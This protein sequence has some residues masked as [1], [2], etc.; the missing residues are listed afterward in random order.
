MICLRRWRVNHTGRH[1]GRV[2]G[3]RLARTDKESEVQFKL[4]AT[5]GSCERVN[6]P[7]LE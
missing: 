6:N 1:K 7:E 2:L 3:H 4:N 5:D